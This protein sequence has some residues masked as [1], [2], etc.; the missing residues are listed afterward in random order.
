M[1]D[2]QHWGLKGQKWGIRRW[3]YPDG[4]FTEEGKIRYGRKSVRE[5]DSKEL[6]QY[7]NDIRNEEALQKMLEKPGV[8]DLIKSSINETVKDETKKTVK[9]GLASLV[10]AVST[11]SLFDDIW[12]AAANLAMPATISIM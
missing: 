4:R 9:N 6:Q 12:M 2:I 7:L 8:M 3:Q 5:L 1:N 10:T 11:T